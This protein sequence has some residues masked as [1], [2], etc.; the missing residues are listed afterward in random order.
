MKNL[1]CS[2]FEQLLFKHSLTSCLLQKDGAYILGLFMEGAR[3]DRTTQV[4]E[5][6]QPKILYDSM[7]V[8]W[9]KPGCKTDIR[10]D[11]SYECP[12]KHF[13]YFIWEL[14]SLCRLIS[15]RVLTLSQCSHKF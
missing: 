5:E 1:K 10:H 15:R 9:L 12:G 7:P 14:S 11:N 4:I 8:I 13:I 3:W 2:L 6:S